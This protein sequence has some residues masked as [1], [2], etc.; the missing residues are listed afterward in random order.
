MSIRFSSEQT[1]TLYPHSPRKARLIRLI[2][3]LPGQGNR[4]IFCEL[5]ETDLER[6]RIIQ[7]AVLRVRQWRRL[8]PEAEIICDMTPVKV[9][10]NLSAALIMLWKTSTALLARNRPTRRALT[11][12]AAETNDLFGWQGDERNLLKLRTYYSTAA[13]DLRSKFKEGTRDIF[14]AFCA[15]YALFEG[16]PASKI[17]HHL[18]HF[19]L[20]GPLSSEASRRWWS[21][22]VSCGQTL[23][24]F[25]RLVAEMEATRRDWG[26]G[27]A[28]GTPAP[29]TQVPFR[30]GAEPDAPDYNRDAA[31]MFFSF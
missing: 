14:G 20:A 26:S 3:L 27:R 19:Y 10:P 16:A 22:P 25:S 28:A 21:R 2:V 5:H 29:A 18:R 1:H 13:Y 15:L 8:S 4:R 6:D 11:A 9:C 31:S 30:A 23:T 7:S 12:A 24:H 17:Q